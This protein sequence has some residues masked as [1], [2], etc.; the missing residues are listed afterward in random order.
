MTR[1]RRH[2]ILFV[3]EPRLGR[4]KRRLARDIGAPAALRF[5]Q[6]RGFGLVG[7]I[8]DYPPGH[9]RFILVKRFG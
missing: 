5:Y 8:P 4:V 9:T 2:L 6:R 7:T 3:K 1:D